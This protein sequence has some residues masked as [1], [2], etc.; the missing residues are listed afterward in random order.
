MSD[1]LGFFGGGFFGED[2]VLK[3]A[4]MYV[5]RFMHGFAILEMQVNEIFDNLLQLTRFVGAE[6]NPEVAVMI[7]SQLDTRKKLKLI[8]L[9]LRYQGQYQ[10]KPKRLLSRLHELHDQRNAIAH[11]LFSASEEG[12]SFERIDPNRPLGS[13]KREGR[14]EETDE[15]LDELRSYSELDKLH[16]E[17]AELLDDLRHV[18][19]KPIIDAD[20]DRR[21]LARDIEEIIQSSDNV[22]RFARRSEGADDSE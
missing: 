7:L 20:I 19:I 8:E 2:K 5:G 18:S 11:S 13:P 16:V 10:G 4:W 1:E 14:A 12:I 17:M 3:K 21:Q 6:F 15:D 22:I 9:G